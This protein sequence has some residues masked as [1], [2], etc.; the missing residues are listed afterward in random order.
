MVFVAGIA[1]FLHAQAGI[2]WWGALLLFLAPDLSFAGYGFGPKSERSATMPR[3]S[4]GSV[5]ACSRSARW[6]HSRAAP[7]WARCGW[8]TPASIGCSA[9]A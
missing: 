7:R 9:T 5:P 2:P 6:P 1:L 3:I 4:M 8:R